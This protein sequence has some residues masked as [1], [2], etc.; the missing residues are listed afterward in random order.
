MGGA[1]TTKC[2]P[3]SLNLNLEGKTGLVSKMEKFRQDVHIAC[4]LI[5][6]GEWMNEI[7]RERAG[8]RE[9]EEEE[10]RGSSGSEGGCEGE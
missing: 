6:R 4:T 10:E 8:E 7:R 5:L 9:E 3:S 2:Q 1:V